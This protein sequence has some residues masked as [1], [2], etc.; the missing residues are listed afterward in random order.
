MIRPLPI[1]PTLLV[2]AVVS[3]LVGL[4]FW[5][6]QRAQERDRELELH[7]RNA[8]A[9]AMA[10]PNQAV[11]DQL[12]FRK[13]NGFCLTPKG[14]HSLGAGA[15]GFRVIASCRSGAE[16]PGLTVQLGTTRDPKP[17]VRWRGGPVTGYIDYAPDERPLAERFF[18]RQPR[19]LML[20]AAPPL[21]GLSPNP[22][23][24]SAAETN[25]SWSYA[26][27]WFS[28]AVVALVI[29]GFAVRTKL[30]EPRS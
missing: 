14:Y 20:V 2:L 27:Q 9:P 26:F 1:I 25:S 22:G 17:S 13:A 12:L 10:F 4:G 28:F 24:G 19:M 23:A 7:A 11:D 8:T 16:G 30:R 15:A 21:A 3:V 5:Q 6:L 29:Y 18:H